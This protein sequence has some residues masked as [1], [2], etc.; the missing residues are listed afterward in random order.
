MKHD[1]STEDQLKIGSTS[2]D[3]FSTIFLVF[4]EICVR[5]VNVGGQPLLL[6]AS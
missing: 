1:N 6:K 5:A 2:E 3:Q 4:V